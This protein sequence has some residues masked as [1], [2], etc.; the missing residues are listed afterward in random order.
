MEGGI[1]FG[2]TMALKSQITIS[3]GR[4]VQSNFHDYPLLRIDEIPEIETFIVPST[5][6]PSGTGE[7]G[8]P[9]IAPAVANAIYAATGKRLRRIPF[10]PADV[11]AA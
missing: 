10:T 8:N 7:M 4:V 2:L 5:E 9:P 6:T 11:L 3:K 1:I